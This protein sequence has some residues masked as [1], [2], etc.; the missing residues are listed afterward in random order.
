MMKFEKYSIKQWEEKAKK[1]I[2]A[3]TLDKLM[4]NTPEG[5][6]VKPLY[7]RDD[8]EG[9]IHDIDSLPGFPPFTRG[10]MATMY[11]GKP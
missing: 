2:K 10:P 8:L 11:A 5:F 4:W 6:I 3:D 9:L 1:E 7:T